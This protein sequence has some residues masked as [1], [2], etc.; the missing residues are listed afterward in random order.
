M[1]GYPKSERQFHMTYTQNSMRALAADVSG[2]VYLPGDDGYAAEAAPF[3]LAVTHRPGVIIGA[4][5]AADVQAAVRFAGENAM[6]VAVLNTGHGPSLAATEDAVLITTRR[7]TGVRIDRADQTARVEAGVRW[8]QVVDAA[9]QA[10]LAP[11]AGSSP[12]VGVV[13]YT[14]GGGVSVTMGR[15]FGWAVDHVRRIEVVTADGELRHVTPDTQTDLFFALCGGKSNF[16]VVTALEFALFPVTELYAGALYFAG[17]HAHEVLHAYARF[18]ATAPDEVSSS[19]VLL[20]LPDLPFIPEF[21]RGKLTV[22]VRISYLGTA[23]NGRRLIAPLRAAAPTLVDT[24]EMMPYSQF[25]AISS[26]PTD[27]GAAVEH[28]ALLDE[29]SPAMVETILGVVGPDA[30]SRI[31]MV[32]LRQLGGAL[33]R[34]PTVPNAVG[35]RDA[36]FAVFALTA[37]DPSE[38]LANA[39]SGLELLDRLRAPSGEV[40]KHPS[41]L[42][43]ADATVAAVR[44]AYDDGVY[45]RLQ[46][47][48]SAF[49]PGNMFRLNYN[50]PPRG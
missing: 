42:A 8:G 9:A 46:S 5:N 27:P 3:N 48:K 22:Q 31:T 41:F 43:P 1:S 26:D 33:H 32:D 49:D 7:M 47:A 34:A 19:A 16:G 28:F 25:A 40:R 36:A 11:L 45:E 50:I 15:A 18:S 21:L 24:V 14:L 39:S 35:R 10:G 12:Q 37:V 20:R 4:T 29:L 23:A 30:N 17:A 6:P 38:V 2:P 44:L 13:G